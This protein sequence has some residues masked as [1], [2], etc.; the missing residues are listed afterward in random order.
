LVRLSGEI[1]WCE[2]CIVRNDPSATASG[3]VATLTDITDR[4]RALEETSRLA[5]F[6][7]LLPNPVVEISLD[8][9]VTYINPEAERLFPDLRDL[10]SQHPFL[11]H[12]LTQLDEQSQP[13]RN[14]IVHENRIG[15]AWYEQ[16]V[17]FVPEAGCHRVYGLNVTARKQ[18][19]ERLR[20]QALH[21][22]LTSLPNRALFL[23][24]LNHLILRLQRNSEHRFAVLFFDL[25]NFKT[26]ND[27]LG[28]ATGDRLLLEL[29]RRIQ[30][31]LR[32]EDTVARLGGD[33]FAVLLESIE[34][35]DSG[36]SVAQR[37]LDAVSHPVQA[38]DHEI[39][40]TASVGIAFSRPERADALEFLRDADTAMYQAKRLGKN[41]YVVFDPSMHEAAVHRLTQEFELR[42]ALRRGELSVYYQPIIGLADDRLVGFEALVRWNH[43][44]KGLLD[45]DV[46]IQLAEETGL[47]IPLGQ[48]VLEQSCARLRA[49]RDRFRLPLTMHVNLSVRQFSDPE[50]ER[51]IKGALGRLSLPPEALSLEITE[52]VLLEYGPATRALLTG[53]KDLGVRLCVDDFGTGYSSLTYLHQLP[54]H[55]LKIDRAFVSTLTKNEENKEIIRAICALART[56]R[57]ELVA[58]GVETEEQ[59]QYIKLMECEFAQGWFFAPAL[60]AEEAEQFLEDWKRA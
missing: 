51:W 49:W 14:Y 30:D 58:E 29:A 25:D 21:D 57:L 7:R 17:H 46:F 44:D 40:V 41:R 12:L 56:F 23:D 15:R 45:P 4:K 33:E 27:S 31:C 50:L 42:R 16:I 54:I 39:H 1:F 43:P 53:L 24:R 47:I 34:N 38:G 18:A 37:V 13:R 11:L 9:E 6:P 35:A 60:A 10:G 36:V 19:E 55:A 59:Y 8:G 22:A 48:W 26:I 32:P 5:S 52:S 28:H 20:F 2:I 3:Y